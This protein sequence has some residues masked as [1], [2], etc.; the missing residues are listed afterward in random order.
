MTTSD[1]V[2]SIAIGFTVNLITPMIRNW[3]VAVYSNV[4]VQIKGTSKSFLTSQLRR[5]QDNLSWYEEKTASDALLKWLLPHLFTQLVWLCFVVIATVSSDVFRSNPELPSTFT[6]WFDIGILI[7][8]IRQA[9]MFILL[10]GEVQKVLSIDETRSRIC[11]QIKDIESEL[12]R[13]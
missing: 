11:K 12:E 8:A 9:I 5:L 2:I 7:M 3:L 13:S 1:I 10:G 4:R 6:E